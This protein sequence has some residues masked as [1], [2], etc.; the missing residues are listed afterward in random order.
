MS[1]TS[2]HPFR[3]QKAKD[4]Y[5]KRYDMRAQAWPVASETKTV[6]TS[7]GHT[8]VRICGPPEGR[9]LVL[10]PSAAASSLIW[11]M[12]VEALSA[13]Y[14]VYAVDN[15]YDFGRSA[16][17]RDIKSANDLTNWLDG[18]FDALQL[19]NNIN[20]MGL[21]YG[22][23]ITGLYALRHPDRL[24]KIVM[25]APPATVFPLPAAWVWY[26]LTGLIPHR[27]FLRNMTRWMF[28]DLTRKEDE[29]SR[30]LLENL[31]EDAFVGLR[32]FKLKMPVA[33][34]VLTD[35]QLQSIKVPALFLVGEN[36]VIYPAQ[37]AI[38]RLK[39]V[40]PS[41]RAEIIPDAGHDLTIVQ[42]KMVNEKVLDF[43]G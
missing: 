29:A 35:E 9:P 39:D 31:V 4:R 25:C 23:W 40:A 36:E 3:S 8:F 41:I 14:R 21:S 34:T 19:G 13:H 26:G 20:L 18:L 30:G 32:C 42:A 11:M 5:L 27:Y 33:P 6:D 1:T 10:L 15:I 17:S 7:Y 12:N 43:L 38:Q 37:N 24:G 2:Y 22:A 28:K 16:N